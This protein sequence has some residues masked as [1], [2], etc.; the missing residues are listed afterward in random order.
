MT[1]TPSARDSIGGD[2][3]F[4]AHQPQAVRA[5]NR[6]HRHLPRERG[7]AEDA[8]ADAGL[9]VGGVQQRHRRHRLQ[10]VDQE[11]RGKRLAEDHGAVAGVQQHRGRRLRRAEHV[12]AADVVLAHQPRQHV[13]RVAVGAQEIRLERRDDELA[14]LL[15]R[16]QLLQRL[17]DPALGGAIERERIARRGGH[18]ARPATA[19]DDT[20]QTR[21]IE[22]RAAAPHAADRSMRPALQCLE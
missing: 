1:C 22:T 12:E 7:R 17:L 18:A 19:R 6:A 5:G 4:L 2:P 20:Q 8:E 10:P 14:D 9:E 13:E 3:R 16:R 15:V 21:R 11:R